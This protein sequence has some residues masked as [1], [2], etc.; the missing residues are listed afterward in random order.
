ML[1]KITQQTTILCIGHLP[2]HING[3]VEALKNAGFINAVP[4]VF[5]DTTMTEIKQ[6]IKSCPPGTLFL[7]GGAM[8]MTHP[9]ATLELYDFIAT[10]VPTMLIH[11][12]SFADFP[13]GTKPPVSADIVAQAAVTVALKMLN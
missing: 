12:V 4:I 2:S 3:K 5:S 1:S 10:E 7:S 9:E 11:K 6:L 13:E 8:A